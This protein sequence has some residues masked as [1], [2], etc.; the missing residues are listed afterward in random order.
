MSKKHLRT[1]KARVIGRTPLACYLATMAVLGI[2]TVCTYER[3]ASEPTQAELAAS[4]AAF[5]RLLESESGDQLVL[6]AN[7][8]PDRTRQL[9]Y[10]AAHAAGIDPATF[11]GLLLTENRGRLTPDRSHKG[12]IGPAQLMPATA[13]E[14]G[15]NPHDAVENVA[16]GAVYLG[17]MKRR[18]GS[19][20]LGLVAYNMGPGA[21]DRW[22]RR[23]AKWSR[24][25]KETRDY[26]SK[27]KVN[28]ALSSLAGRESQV[29][30]AGGR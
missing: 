28:A 26:V 7:H 2:A 27:V 30:S 20:T 6:P 13:R 11:H 23:G 21:T 14:L 29:A 8:A 15:V 3:P 16:G 19:E 17:R 18:F 10:D 25:P 1:S 24:L 12:A 9:A 22:I 4:Q 5:D